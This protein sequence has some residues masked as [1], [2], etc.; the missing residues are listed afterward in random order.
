MGGD[1]GDCPTIARGEQTTRRE[2]EGDGP[3]AQ[4]QRHR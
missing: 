2:E 3:S 1:D 4:E